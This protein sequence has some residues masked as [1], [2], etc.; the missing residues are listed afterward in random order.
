MA[1]GVDTL[2][3]RSGRTYSRIGSC[4]TVIFVVS[5]NGR[6]RLDSPQEFRGQFILMLH[7]ED[8]DD[9]A[10]QCVNAPTNPEK[11]LLQEWV[12]SVST[13]E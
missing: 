13:N 4:Q 12:L 11:L 10:N 6:I 7:E 9:E 3:A 5:R 2:V 8:R 1:G